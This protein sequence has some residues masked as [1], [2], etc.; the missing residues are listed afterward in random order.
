MEIVL[1]CRISMFR[2]I[3]TDETIMNIEIYLQGN[4]PVWF[5]ELTELQ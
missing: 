4:M 2:L 3:V 1:C 5:K